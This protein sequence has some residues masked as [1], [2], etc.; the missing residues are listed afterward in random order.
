M[1]IFA[2]HNNNH[3]PNDFY[4]FSWE[5]RTNIEDVHEIYIYKEHTNLTFCASAYAINSTVAF[6]LL[7]KLRSKHAH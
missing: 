5:G 1:F 6:L 3:S 2:L 7:L 4:K